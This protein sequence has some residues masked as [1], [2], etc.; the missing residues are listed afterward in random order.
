MPKAAVLALVLLLPLCARA[1]DIDGF[2]PVKPAQPILPNVSE[3]VGQP[4]LSVPQLPQ[5]LSGIET[6]GSIPELPQAAVEAANPETNAELPAALS[7]PQ[8][9]LQTPEANLVPGTNLPM[10]KPLADA[11]L[12]SNQASVPNWLSA[13]WE[14]LVDLENAVFDGA[15]RSKSGDVS[16]KVPRR[17]GK[18]KPADDEE[19]PKSPTAD[20]GGGP[21]YPSRILRFVGEKFRSVLFRPN[22]PV[23][24]E[25][26]RAINT[27]RKSIHI[28]LYEFKQTA[29]LA[30]LR[31]ARDRGVQIHIILDYKNV[32][33]EEASIDPDNP[34]AP[35]YKAARSREIW[36]L[37]REGFDVKV[38]KGLGDY[39]IDHNK[40]AIF[41]AGEAY[42][43]G[44]FGSYNWNWTAEEDHY[45][46]ANFTVDKRRTD[47]MMSYWNWLDS[48]AEPI[49]YNHKNGMIAMAN[50]DRQWPK[51][52]P[53]P[54]IKNIPTL[55][56]H[57]TKL[58]IIVLSP[59]RNPGESIEDRLVQA[60]QATSKLKDQSKR[61]IDISIFALRST[62]I[63]EALVAAHKA[64]TKVR[65]IMD[66]RQATDPDAE[67]VFGIYAQYL[68][69]NG[70]EVRTLAGPDPVN[71]YQLAQKD[72][73]KFSIFAGELVETGSANYTTYAAIGNFENGNF[74]DEEE[75]VKGYSFIYEHMWGKATK[76]APPAAAPVL[77]THDQL[78]A[79]IDK[80]QSG[81][82][83]EPTDPADPSPSDPNAMKTKP[84]DIPFNGGIL[85]SF[86]FRP[87]T[88]VEP[89]IIKAIG[90]AKKSIRLSLYE[91]TLDGVLDA[92]RDAKK[93]GLKIEIVIDRS[94]V[95]TTGKDHTGQ[96]RKP[97]PE[98]MAL[99]E[100]KFDVK[101][102]RGNKSGIQHNKYA[103]FDAED[104]ESGGGL[105][106]FGSYNWAS[107]AEHNHFENIMFSNEAARIKGKLA[108]H[109]F[110]RGLA[111]EVDAD[112][113][114]EVL[115][116]GH[117][118]EAEAWDREEA[119]GAGQEDADI[120][121]AG[122]R[123]PRRPPIPAPPEDKETPFD[124]NG[125]KF[126]REYYSPN[127]GILDAWLRA[128]K[129]AKTSIDIGMFSFYSREA[130]E[131]IVAAV[132]QAKKENRDF[133]V[134]LVLDAGQSALAKLDGIPIAQWFLEKGIDVKQLAGPNPDRDPMF[135]KQHSKFI[136][137]DGKFLMTGSFNL[138]DTADNNNFE[139]ENV[140]MD[141]TDV[142]GF[143]EWFER[144]YQKGWTP[145]ERKGKAKP[146]PAKTGE[147]AGSDDDA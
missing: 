123:G 86:A 32:F 8:T 102:L 141:P 46:N 129:A 24:S 140:I 113:L 25:I 106:L 9:P 124:L 54:P 3:T 103:V 11:A 59:N 44:I 47:V 110:Q 18:G 133:R 21:D 68:A 20:D 101:I 10:P 79:E 80:P 72:H 5:T 81:P 4:S 88:P 87:E 70:I 90:L 142:A 15:A 49:A 65:V 143:V 92:L 98:I 29:V 96:P 61:T 125:E 135:E 146:A 128:I 107:T 41:D 62:K 117:D 111:E 116:T 67:K 28:S 17:S 2:G 13:P 127:G 138:S 137:V 97:S 85:P 71:G 48:L 136:L 104:I 115:S 42:S 63:A 66:Q 75:D 74:I 120:E 52:V 100:E 130:A 108:Y 126:Q 56:F 27:A 39:G 16:P 38:L 73:H 34:K 60:I 99:I 53:A 64:G 114:E 145:R 58:P 69:F 83:A 19:E 105:T 23:E 50:P 131:A 31:Q 26:V 6:T 119:A 112:K 147:G 132:E 12:I 144:L 35:K 94:H 33:P 43:M 1:I 121:A 7:E 95:Y 82:E 89:L 37:A 78:V 134:R 84:R 40:I 55:D 91:F 118:A 36:A 51:T 14:N 77:P 22:V 109:Q 30:A 93:R 139:N 45:E 76:L 57:G 122:L